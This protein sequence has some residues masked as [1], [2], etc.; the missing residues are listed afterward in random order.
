MVY[1]VVVEGSKEMPR[2]A[3][4]WPIAEPLTNLSQA[5]HAVNEADPVEDEVGLMSYHDLPEPTSFYLH[6]NDSRAQEAVFR[7]NLRH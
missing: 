6:A 7:L 4:I 1:F 2:T 5:L 3:A